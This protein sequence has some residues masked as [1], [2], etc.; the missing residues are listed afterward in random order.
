V[1]VCVGWCSL[2]RGDGCMDGRLELEERNCLLSGTREKMKREFEQGVPVENNK[3]V[4]VV[5]SVSATSSIEVDSL[6][7]DNG[8]EGIDRSKTLMPTMS[9]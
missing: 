9:L 1:V 8:D 3:G 4:K 2:R 5:T 7:T 6:V